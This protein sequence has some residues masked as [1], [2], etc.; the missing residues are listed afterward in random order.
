M[1][2]KL[3]VQMDA[4]LYDKA[5]RKAKGE[6]GVPLSSIIKLYLHAFIS[7]RGAGFLVADQEMA[8][9]FDCYLNRKECERKYGKGARVPGPRLT[10]L[11]KF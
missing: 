10:K 4:K 6:F 11:Y 5:M 9:R 8:Q 2:K 3:T 7:Q 1:R